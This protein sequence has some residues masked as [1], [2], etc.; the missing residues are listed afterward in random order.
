MTR[1][2]PQAR[3][4]SR[5]GRLARR[6]GALI[7]GLL[8]AA[9]VGGFL[10]GL[11]VALV[12]FG[13]DPR[14]A[15]PPAWDRIQEVITSR[16]DDTIALT[17]LQVAGWGAWVV[18]VVSTLVEIG[19][20]LATAVGW[21]RGPHP[22]FARLLG[23]PA[24]Y[25]ITWVTT[26]LVTAPHPAA[27]VTTHVAVTA[28]AP[29]TPP[30][31]TTP[32]TAGPSEWHTSHPGGA[33]APGPAG[34][35]GLTTTWAAPTTSNTRTGSSTPAVVRVGPYDSLWRIAEQHLGDGRR[36]TEIY[37]LNTDRLQP[38]GQR[39]TDPTLLRPG[40]TLL[41][42]TTGPAAPD[43]TASDGAPATTG[44][45]VIV[46]RPGDTLSGLAEQHL[47]TTH[48]TQALYSANQGRLQPDGDRLTN[49]DLIRPGWRLI[50]PASNRADPAPPRRPSPPRTPHQPAPP[51]PT[52]SPSAH[53][54]APDG[55]APPAS[56][57]PRGGTAP[58]ATP[59]AASATP[60]PTTAPA[61]T[62]SA[63]SDPRGPVT[64]SPTAVPGGQ[65]ADRDP[66][67]W[68][69]LP[70]GS[71]L[72]LGLVTVIA[73]LVELARRRRRQHR[74]TA[75]PQPPAP[76]ALAH[77]V[78]EAWYAARRRSSDPDE[79]LDVDLDDGDVGD[80]AGEGE[81]D[82]GGYFGPLPADPDHPQVVPRILLIPTAGHAYTPS[83]D[84]AGAEAT[85]AVTAAR[86]DTA[87][88]LAAPSLL[89]LV[90]P[91]DA[92]ALA[93]RIWSSGAGLT[94]PGA[95]GVARA[96]LARLLTSTGPMGGELVITE[97]ALAVLL[98][99]Q[100][101]QRFEQIPG[102]RVV[103]TLKAGVARC[104]ADMLARSRWLLAADVDCLAD[105]RALPD[106]EPVAAVLL[107]AHA[108]DTAASTGHT[109]RVLRLGQDLDL[110][111]VLLGDWPAG[112][113]TVA[114]DGTLTE[115]PADPTTDAAGDPAGAVVGRAE[116][117]TA[118]D[119]TDLFTG[120]LPPL[121][122][123]LDILD[124]TDLL[125]DPRP[126]PPPDPTNPTDPAGDA[127]DLPATQ[128]TGDAAA[129]TDRHQG[130]LTRANGGPLAAGAVL[131]IAVFG[132]VRILTVIDGHEV[133]GLREK[134]RDLLA[135]LA[136]HPDGLSTDQIGEALWP[137]T[138]PRRAAHRLSTTLSLAREF[139]RT[140]I[141]THHNPNEADGH[142]PAGETRPASGG[143]DGAKL[144]L[145]PQVDGRYHLD[146]ALID[147]EYRRFTAAVT[148]AA[149]AARSGDGPGRRAALQ[150]I[151]DLY[152]DE[153]LTGLDYTWV[154]PIRERTRRQAADALAALA[155]LLAPSPVTGP[156]TTRAGEPPADTATAVPGP[157]GGESN[158]SGRGDTA[159]ALAALERAIEVDPYD[160]DLYRRVMRLHAAAGR[161]DAVR[162]TLRLLEARL[163]D[164]LDTDPEQETRDLAA[165]LLRTPP[166]RT[167]PTR[168]VPGT[169]PTGT[170]AVPAGA[171]RATP[172]RA[173]TA[174][175][176]QPNPTPPGR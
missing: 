24:A 90:G 92:A 51:S 159:E 169:G 141:P 136:V 27:A 116:V 30:V 32:A 109:E 16:D 149:Q 35:A 170:G 20:A 48:A 47:G 173:R 165:E 110:G 103:A 56:P 50:L 53:L 96:I 46:V 70:S 175:N 12:R 76:P 94:G 9:V 37:A 100:D 155:D 62:A 17:V 68:V 4:G 143:E 57:P 97:A 124:P 125:A 166:R 59:T 18:L 19:A 83:P 140:A 25:L 120:L 93:Q 2:R 63:P 22:R 172:R 132:R 71:V 160:E 41:L 79:D 73:G 164:D 85:D 129:R 87:G 150:A 130:P 34:P 28:P 13:G 144:N 104:E 1:P 112:T 58:T 135:L 84:E 126:A 168:P 82:L 10:V 162:R 54:P 111:A 61:S 67:G 131:D 38:D 142:E 52:S 113:L 43:T 26:S 157:I 99:D 114:A 7:R 138:Q 88:L 163:G 119:A 80:G 134:V 101:P 33:P 122:D 167:T 15:R 107:V 36:W 176:S 42:P 121:R 151:A 156:E 3:R 171:G 44:D 153:A 77:A 75:D 106:V 6:V 69:Q 154:E 72:G 146:P 11:P 105:Y 39:L 8:A 60:R 128:D 123:A 158:G 139:L 81:G 91:P 31:S 23:R 127:G 95:S 65:R 64:T 102:I 161:R 49:P 145:V 133:T 108:P 29:A 147:T 55:S 117:L 78:E 152:R 148:H 66:G 118:A 115:P 5:A 14:S 98:P 86:G 174:P 45:R 137:E 40:W 74:T 89:A 21:T